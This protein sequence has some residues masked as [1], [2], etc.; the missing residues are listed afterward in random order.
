MSGIALTIAGAARREAWE[1]ACGSDCC[2]GGLQ[3]ATLSARS[4]QE[5]HSERRQRRFGR[6]LK[7]RVLKRVIHRSHD[8]VICLEKTRCAEANP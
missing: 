4:A 2:R 5:S 8:K 1:S 6:I 7:R 3:P